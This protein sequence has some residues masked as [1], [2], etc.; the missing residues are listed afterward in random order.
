MVEHPF[1][2]RGWAKVRDADFRSKSHTSSWFP[3]VRRLPGF[4]NCS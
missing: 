1:G 4:T 2:T 3:D